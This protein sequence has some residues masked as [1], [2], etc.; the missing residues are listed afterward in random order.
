MGYLKYFFVFILI[1]ISVIAEATH[2]RAGEVIAKR[3]SGLTY[4]FTFIGYRDVDGVPFGNGTF[5]FGDGTIFGGENGDTIP[6]E[7]PVDIA[8]G[9]QQWEFSLTHTYSAGSSYLV[10]YRE[11]FRNADIQNIS[12]SI[13]TS[14]YVE[15]LVIVDALI[16]NSTP[17]FTVPPIDQGVVGGIFE[18]NPGA[19]DPD[20]DSLSYIFTIPK[21]DNG[22]DVNGY[23]TLIDPAFYTNFAEGNQAKDGI[24]TLS[25]DPVTGTLVWDAP[26]GATIPPE[27]NREF[28]V[29]F[30]VEEW[31]KIGGVPTR[32]GFVTRDMQIIIWNFENDPPELEIP[33][34]TC[35]IAGE[36]VTATVIGT[37]PDG[38]PVKL[39]AFGGPFEVTPS[40]TFSPDPAVFQDSPA[41]L[42]FE[43]TTSCSQVRL[44]PYEVQFKGTDDPIIP[45]IP[46][47]PGQVNFETWRISV[48]GPAPTGLQV[49]DTTGRRFHLVWDQYSCTNADSMQ[50]WRRVGEFDIDTTCEPGMPANSGYEL[51]E[52][53]QISDTSY[54]D[55]NNGIG[56]STGSKYCYRLVATFPFPS[57]GESIV[58]EEACDSLLIDVPIITNVDITETSETDGEIRVRW[59]PPYQIDQTAFPPTYTYEVLRKE[60][61]GFGGNFISVR[62]RSADT[63]FIDT[64]LN[65]EDISY[66]Y[67]IA[68]FYDDDQ[69]LDTSQQASSVRLDPTPLI[70][71]IQLDWDANVPWSNTVQEFPFHYIYRDNVLD[72][73]LSALQL[74][75]SVDVTLGGLSYVDDGRFN[76]I[77][78][79]EEIEYCYFVTTSGSYDNDLLPSPLVN[80]SQII[81]AQPNDSIPPCAPVSLSFTPDASFSCEN[82]YSCE[83]QAAGLDQE[84]QNVLRW[85][86]DFSPECGDDI[87]F[88]RVYISRPGDLETFVE[89]G[90]TTES[91]FV[92]DQDRFNNNLPLRSL[93]FCYYITAV[94]RSGNESQISGILCNDNCT[95]YIL[96]NIFT[97]NGDSFNETFAP[98]RDNGECPRFVE[99]VI[100]KVFNRTGL[101]V[102]NYNSNDRAEGIEGSA[103]ARNTIFINWDGKT[104]SGQELPAGVYFYSAEVR[105]LTLNPEDANEVITGWV[106]IVR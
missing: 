16:T 21:Q 77:D 100:F 57:G 45:G 54:L 26:G 25:I 55:D 32:L 97:P 65:T 82:Q 5:D 39:E 44:T 96:P 93:A 30:V 36:T 22:L 24:P 59:T 75:D 1:L 61:Q 68:L 103:S 63:T 56:L 64:G 87:D 72:A 4:Q 33:P 84:L 31:R 60:G 28:N 42:D 3:V 80:N 48:V 11:D 8:E 62:P 20:G 79:D 27:E 34:D 95:Q 19:F 69:P 94:D 99:S 41:S 23:R 9:V 2:I 47:P 102:F 81:C 88:F 13:S 12:G 18:H 76:G 46:N 29:A 92:H 52:T 83:R 40:A 90:T 85:E 35:V 10:S 89:L 98:M 14:F 53:L 58:S 91:E 15:T 106:Q 43:W 70:G 50:V 104:D 71:G 105:Y 78:L 37:D 49:S 86:A 6:W 66:S 74:I 51:I 67:K 7:E 101:E 73:D 38:D 17:F